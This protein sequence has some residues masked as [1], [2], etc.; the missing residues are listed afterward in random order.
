[1]TKTKSLLMVAVLLA[2]SR[3]FAIKVVADRPLLQ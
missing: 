1:M 3:A 2:S